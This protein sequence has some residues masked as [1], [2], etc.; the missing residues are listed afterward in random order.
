M[1]WGWGGGTVL[2]VWCLVGVEHLSS[3]TCLSRYAV[4]FLVLWLGEPAFLGPFLSVPAGISGCQLLQH[5][6]WDISGQKKAQGSHHLVIPWVLQS[7]AML[8]SLRLPESSYI[9]F[10]SNA[11]GLELHLEE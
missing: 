10:L 4:P 2:S 6:V 5:L 11:W 9:C 7:L 8:P 1:L 3:K